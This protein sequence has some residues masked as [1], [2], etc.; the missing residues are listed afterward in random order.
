[1][2]ET[3]S[4]HE[5]L[6]TAPQRHQ[7]TAGLARSNR[8]V[9]AAHRPVRPKLGVYLQ[10]KVLKAHLVAFREE[11]GISSYRLSRPVPLQSAPLR[12]QQGKR[13]QEYN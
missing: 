9:Q 7:V 5:N 6:P 1:M 13:G 2:A 10:F 4:G 11:R 8:T 12:A 3:L